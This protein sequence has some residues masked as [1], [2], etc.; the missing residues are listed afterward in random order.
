MV[1]ENGPSFWEQYVDAV[2]R[3]LADMKTDANVSVI[4]VFVLDSILF[5]RK[6]STM[7]QRESRQ[8]MNWTRPRYST[9]LYHIKSF[10]FLEE[11]RDDNRRKVACENDR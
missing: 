2:G 1:G 9:R 6:L 4:L 3:Y 11:F 7:N 8:T 5:S 10:R